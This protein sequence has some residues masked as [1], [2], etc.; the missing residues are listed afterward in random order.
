MSVTIRDIAQKLE[1]AHSTVSRALRDD[2]RISPATRERVKRVAAQMGYHV[3][4]AARALSSGRMQSIALIIPDVVDPFWAGIVKGVDAVTHERRYSLV[5]YITHAEREREAAALA[6]AAEG[7]YDGAIFF[8]RQL[9]VKDMARALRSGTQL[10]LM[11]HHEPSLPV[12]SVRVDDLDGAYRATSYLL[13]LGHRRIAHIAGPPDHRETT[14]REAGFRQALAEAGIAPDCAH[15][16]SGNFTE[17]GGRAAA[18]SLFAAPQGQWPTAIF[19]AN[20][21]MAI[22]L[23]HFCAERGVRIP[24]DLSIVGYDDIESCRHLQPPLTTVHQPTTE[25][26]GQAARLLIERLEGSSSPPREVWLK[27]ELIV[28][29]SCTRIA[30]DGLGSSS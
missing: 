1:M 3:N 30:G 5:L 11:S 10:S 27:T 23:L 28:R 8:R 25:M 9:P 7:R 21:R 4:V 20:D 19:A 6:A 18:E 16:I 24:H 26:G 14:D 22:G 12:D 13:E 17:K 15:V 2:P 29:G